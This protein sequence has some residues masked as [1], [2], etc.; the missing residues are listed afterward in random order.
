[1]EITEEEIRSLADSIS[2]ED[3]AEIM[4]DALEKVHR[5]IEE[6][7]DTLS[8]DEEWTYGLFKSFFKTYNTIYHLSLGTSYVFRPHIKYIDIKTINTQIRSCHE[9]Y[10]TFQYI[11]CSRIVD[12]SKEERDFKYTCYRLAGALDN[13]RTYEQIKDFSGYRELYEQQIGHVQEEIDVC[14]RKISKS[15]IY[16]LLSKNARD[17]VR[18][19]YWK[20]SAEGRLSWNDLLACTSMPKTY[21]VFEYNNLSLYA[22]SSHA[23]L[24]LE[25]QHDYN[26]IGALAH[27]YKLCAFMCYSTIAAFELGSPLDK[28]TFA[29][30]IDLGR[31][32]SSIVGSEIS[33]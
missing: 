4:F 9:L 2:N 25:A 33:T 21:G 28:R 17:A 19:G 20:V 10:L 32:G 15:R 29:L 8:I 14:R 16:K 24:Q 3:V 1:M 5:A 30:V 12:G 13:K 7:V 23:S 26:M 18:K 11:T 27:I 31:M 6:K 22:H